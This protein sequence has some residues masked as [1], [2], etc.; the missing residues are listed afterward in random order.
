MK[1]III[2]KTF[3]YGIL[4][5]VYEDITRADLINEYGIQEKDILYYLPLKITGRNYQEKRENLR[6]LAIEY[7]STYYEFCNYSYGEL[8]ILQNFFEVYGRKY[9]LI[10]EF[11]ENCII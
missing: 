6:N 7:Q 11:K 4:G 8:S 5:G 3:P 10:T 9:G 2:Y 1:T